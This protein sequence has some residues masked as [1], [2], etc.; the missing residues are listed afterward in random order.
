M[1][2][3]VTIGVSVFYLTRVSGVS[4]ILQITY[5]S[6]RLFPVFLAIVLALVLM[7]ARSSKAHGEYP[8]AVQEVE[9]KPSDAFKYYNMGDEFTLVV[10]DRRYL[11]DE[12]QYHSSRAHWRLE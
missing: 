8:E 4:G 6:V 7:T 12:W 5:F 1:G 11:L 2:S 3:A 10:R 9:G